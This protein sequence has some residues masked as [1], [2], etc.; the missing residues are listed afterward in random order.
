M[1]CGLTYVNAVSFHTTWQLVG[2]LFGCSCD[3]NQ[4]IALEGN[5]LSPILNCVHLGLN[6]DPVWQSCRSL[7]SACLQP[8]LTY[9]LIS[10]SVHTRRRSAPFLFTGS[11]GMSF[12]GSA[13]M[14]FNFCA[15]AS[16]IPSDCGTRKVSSLI[17]RPNI[18]GKQ[19]K[20]MSDVD[21]K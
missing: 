5:V 7:P 9:R 11:A 13:G 8:F 21:S 1:L 2:C 20:L 3:A 4:V 19:S 17:V 14:S 18:S 16:L 15:I 6:L 10:I 12:T